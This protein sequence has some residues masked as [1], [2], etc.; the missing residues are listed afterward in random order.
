MSENQ[1]PNIMKEP[2]RVLWIDDEYELMEPFKNL[3][4]LNNI[5]L[6]GFKSLTSGVEELEKNY[7]SYDTVILDAIIL[8]NENDPEGSEHISHIFRAQERILRLSRKK[9][10]DMFVLTGQP[11]AY[12]SSVFN[13]AFSKVYTKGNEKDIERL[14]EDIKSSTA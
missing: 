9:K 4:L 10:F 7:A 1:K 11:E 6:V 14:F 2:I 8:E 5:Q 12:N 13:M 3:A